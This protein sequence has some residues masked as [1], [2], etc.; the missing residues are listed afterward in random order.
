M[1]KILSIIILSLLILNSTYAEFGD[2]LYIKNNNSEIKESPINQAKTI[3]KL[4]KWY[5]ILDQWINKLDYTKVKLTDWKT[6]YILSSN[7]WKQESNNLEIKWNYWTLETM[8]LLRKSPSSYWFPSAVA[9][10][11]DDFK[12]LHINYLN[13]DWLKIEITSWKNKWKIWYIKKEISQLKCNNTEKNEQLFN[14]FK[15]NKLTFFI[16]FINTQNTNN[17]VNQYYCSRKIDTQIKKTTIKKETTRIKPN[18]TEEINNIIKKDLPTVENYRKVMSDNLLEQRKIIEI[19]D[20]NQWFKNLFSSNDW[21]SKNIDEYY[22]ARWIHI[23]TLMFPEND[24]EI[25]PMETNDNEFLSSLSDLLTGINKTETDPIQMTDND[26][27]KWLYELLIDE[28]NKE[29]TIAWME[30][31]DFL[32][33][34]SNL[35]IKEN[36]SETDINSF[37]N[38]LSSLLGDNY[39]WT[40]TKKTDIDWFLNNLNDLLK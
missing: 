26:F 5:I 24:N 10:K 18:E 7:I 13:N 32:K 14:M 38:S 28:N 36:N 17:Y 20:V 9:F 27:I 34:I 25:N 4:K 15:E 37:L 2:I 1:K 6:W 8:S 16:P 29:I 3:A 30:D 31:S 40:Q 22:K 35:L 19:P 39:T 23:S 21:L 12:I 33:E 11:W